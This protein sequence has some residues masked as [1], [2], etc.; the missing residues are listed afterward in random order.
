MQTVLMWPWSRNSE[1]GSVSAVR[2]TLASPLRASRTARMRG[3]FARVVGPDRRV[4]SFGLN[5]RLAQPVAWKGA[6][7]A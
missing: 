2:A 7:T 4:C 1:C 3:F 5:P 6:L